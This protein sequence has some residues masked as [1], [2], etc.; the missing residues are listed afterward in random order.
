M[1]DLTDDINNNV[2][3][4]VNVYNGESDNADNRG[5]EHFKQPKDKYGIGIAEQVKGDHLVEKCHAKC[6]HS[7]K[8][9]AFPV[10]GG[11]IQ[12]LTKKHSSKRIEKE[13]LHPKPYVL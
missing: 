8:N 7:D 2:N 4:V 11:M 13:G 5:Q 12:K 9:A 6:D 3:N 10:E 1:R